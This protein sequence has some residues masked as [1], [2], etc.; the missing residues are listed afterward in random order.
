MDLGG[1]EP[2]F[3]QCECGVLPLNHRPVRKNPTSSHPQ[4]TVVYWGVLFLQFNGYLGEEAM[5]TA[6][7]Q[8]NVQKIDYRRIK[9]WIEY[10]WLALTFP[11]LMIRIAFSRDGDPGVGWRIF[12]FVLGAFLV[13]CLIGSPVAYFF[14]N[15]SIAWSS[16]LLAPQAFVIAAFS[17]FIGIV[18]YFSEPKTED[19]E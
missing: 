8:T 16:A 7:P 10:V 9:D 3:P 11:F 13:A 15:W 2:P 19:Y 4:L 12:M 6:M 17:I 5:A 14:Y 18:A 1:I